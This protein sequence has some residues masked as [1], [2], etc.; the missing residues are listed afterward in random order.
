LHPV[1][2]HEASLMQIVS[3]LVYN[4]VKF[5]PPGRRPQVRIWTE[6]DDSEVRLLVKDN[7]VGIPKEARPRLFGMFQRFH[8]D[9]A[10]EGTGIGLAIV[11]KAAE[12]MGGSVDVDSAPG[13]GSTFVVRLRKP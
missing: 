12:R 5:V 3:N 1:L 7:G 6:H 8:A 2:A 13:E 10:Y 9:G 11:R 4:A